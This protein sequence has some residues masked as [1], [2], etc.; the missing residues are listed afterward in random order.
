MQIQRLISEDRKKTR[1]EYSMD[2]GASSYRRF[3][4][5]DDQGMEE[6]IRDYKDGLILYLNSYLDDFSAAEDCVQDAFITLAIKK[7]VYRGDSSFKTWLYTIGRNTALSYMRKRKRQ[8]N[9]LMDECE[10]MS[11]E[12]DLER[13]YLKEEQ[14]ITVRRAVCRLKKDYQQAL[15]LTY[16]EG[17]SYEEAGTIMKRSRKQIENLLY[18]ARKA[19]RSELEKE[20]FAYEEL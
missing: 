5:G 16:F 20:G 6:L 11:A 13:D 2:N 4:D 9:V 8:K 1:K 19:L 15:Y 12:A 18:N 14:K 3:L 7:P 10:K 17:F